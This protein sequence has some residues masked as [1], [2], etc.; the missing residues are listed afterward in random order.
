MEPSWGGLEGCWRNVGIERSWRPSRAIWGLLEV[1]LAAPT[2]R[3]TPHPD[4]RGNGKGR[5]KPLY[6][7][8]K[9]GS[10]TSSLDHSRPE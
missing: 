9:G 3:G 10:R 2:L 6:R 7:K 4:P 8:R 1:I 5:V